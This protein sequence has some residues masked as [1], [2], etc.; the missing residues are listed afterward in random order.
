MLAARKLI[1]FHGPLSWDASA[2]SMGRAERLTTPGA[3]IEARLRRVQ[4]LVELRVPFSLEREELDALNDF[5]ERPDGT[6]AP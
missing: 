3:G 2:V 1:D 5:L 6:D 4:P